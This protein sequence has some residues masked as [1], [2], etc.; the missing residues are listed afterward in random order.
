MDITIKHAGTEE[1]ETNNG[2]RVYL[3]DST[4]SIEC[5]FQNKTPDEYPVMGSMCR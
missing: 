1:T 2:A 4:T 5:A 3:C